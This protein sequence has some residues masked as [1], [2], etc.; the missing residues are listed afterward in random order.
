MNTLET[1]LTTDDEGRGYAAMTPEAVLA[2]LE[3]L[4][5]PGECRAT[6]LAV[7]AE[8]GRDVARKLASSMQAAAESDPLIRE[9]LENVRSATGIDV[10]HAETRAALDEMALTPSLDLASDDAAAIKGLAD[11]RRSRLDVLGL[12]RPRLREVRAILDD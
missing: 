1:E 2:D 5:Y 12:A 10:G 11:N 8:L 7:A 6:I 9:V 4:R 3:E